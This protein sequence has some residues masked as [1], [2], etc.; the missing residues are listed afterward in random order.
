M[1]WLYTIWSLVIANQFPSA[2]WSVLSSFQ[3]LVLVLRPTAIYCFGSVSQLSSTMFPD[4]A[5]SHFLQKS[6]DKNT[7]CFLPTTSRQTKSA[8]IAREHN[9]AFSSWRVRYFPLEMAETI[10]RVIIW[11]CFVYTVWNNTIP[12]GC[13][14]FSSCECIWYLNPLQRLKSCNFSTWKAPLRGCVS[15]LFVSLGHHTMKSGF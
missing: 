5:G 6:S 2:L 1:K 10:C 9:G 13:H 4:A 3:L 12:N 11:W 14:M 7:V 8:T 15:P